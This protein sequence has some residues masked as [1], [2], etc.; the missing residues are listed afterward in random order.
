MTADIMRPDRPAGAYDD[1]LAERRDQIAAHRL[2]TPEDGALPSIYL[3]HG[4]PPV[5][6]DPVWL[7]E[8]SD[9]SLAMPKPRG[10]VIV[11]AHWENAPIAINAVEAGTPLVYDF[12]GFHPRYY[13]LQYPTPDAASLA[14]RVVRSLPAG[15]EVHHHA[16]RGLDHGAFIPLMA[17]Y[18]AADVPVLQVSMPTLDPASLL[19]LGSRLR[20]LR[21]EGILVVGSGFLTHW[22]GGFATGAPLHLMPGFN[23]DFDAWAAELLHTGDIDALADFRHAPGAT[24][25][26]RTVEHFAPLFVTLG[27][28]DSP[29]LPARS[30]IEGTQLT[31]SKRS[32]QIG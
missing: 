6:D 11:S 20:S 21:S 2:W 18:P 10:V 7:R 4:A 17:M 8:L 12:G 31:N 23:A 16:R 5:L 28:A 22:M 15:T 3:S 30:V 24:Q 9:W 26:H 25:A 19:Q 27:A 13:Q 32:V 14:D 1:M 29:D